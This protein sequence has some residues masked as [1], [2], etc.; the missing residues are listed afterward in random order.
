MP[1]TTEEMKA[2]REEML[3]NLDAAIRSES[4]PAQRAEMIAT[5]DE[6][7]ERM[8]TEACAEHYGV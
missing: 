2:M 1:L 5:A 6:Q 3:R 8:F 4:D 7:A